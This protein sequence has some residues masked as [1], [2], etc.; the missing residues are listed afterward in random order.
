MQCRSLAALSNEPRCPVHKIRHSELLKTRLQATLAS[1][2]MLERWRNLPGLM[3]SSA[4]HS[5][6]ITNWLNSIY[7]LI[8]S[9]GSSTRLGRE[10]FALLTSP[11]YQGRYQKMG[12]MGKRI[13]IKFLRRRIGGFAACALLVLPIGGCDTDVAERLQSGKVLAWY[14]LQGR[15]VGSVTPV[16]ASCGPSTRGVLTI[17]EGDFGFDP[18]QSSTIIQGTVGHDGQLGGTFIRQ[19]THHQPIS[20]SFNATAAGEEAITGELVS[21]RCR[22][23]VA[24]RRG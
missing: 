21:G 12:H 14:G 10:L 15:W 24:L 4:P 23:S 18:F 22:W 2:R 17:G 5:I 13:L 16:A 7:Y 19:D 6:A 3:E 8:P 11:L 1:V 9:S 20:I